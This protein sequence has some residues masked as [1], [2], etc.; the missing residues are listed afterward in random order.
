MPPPVV[1]LHVAQSSVDA[2][3]GGHSV[4][5]GGE[6]LRDDGRLEAFLHQTEGSSEPGASSSHHD[7]V[8]GV[9]NLGGGEE[10][11]RG[12][13]DNTSLEIFTTGYW[14]E[15]ASVLV[16]A[17]SWPLTVKEKFFTCWAAG[18]ELLPAFFRSPVILGIPA[19]AQL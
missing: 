11:V 5:P 18:T 6:Q 12:Q 17:L 8:I 10:E 7:R 14:R 16:L 19:M 1:R 4:G 9:V 3:L 15:M 13:S 2:S